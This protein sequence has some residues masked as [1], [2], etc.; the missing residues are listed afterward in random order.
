MQEFFPVANTLCYRSGT[1]GLYAPSM[2]PHI[3]LVQS[4]FI[5][6]TATL[7]A[8][9]YIGW[10]QLGPANL[11]NS[12][13]SI[14]Y[15]HAFGRASLHWAPWSPVYDNTVA[16]PPAQDLVVWQL[17]G[18]GAVFDHT[19]VGLAPPFV[20]AEAGFIVSSS[21]VYSPALL[22]RTA[23]AVGF[24]DAAPGLYSP[25]LAAKSALQ[26]AHL[27]NTPTTYPPSAT[28]GPVY[29]T[30]PSLVVA[31]AQYAPGLYVGAVGV[32]V[33]FVDA[34]AS[35]SAPG[36]TTVGPT[37]V[38]D[39]PVLGG[40]A[41]FSPASIS[42]LTSWLD[43]SKGNL[44]N[45][46]GGPAMEAVGTP[47]P[48]LAAAVSPSG[49]AVAHFA[50][51][52]GRIRSGWAGDVNDF[53]VLYV[54]RATG[55]N[56]GR[57][58]SS[59][60]P[61]SNFLIGFHTSYP[62]AAYN[63][64]LWFGAGTGWNMWSASWPGPWRLYGGDSASGGG[65]RFFVDGLQI[66]TTDT[67]DGDLTRGWAMS[68]YDDSA[69][70]ETMDMDVGEVLVYDRRVSD[71]ERVQLE[72][73]LQAKWLGAG[74]PAGAQSEVYAPAAENIA[75]V[76]GQLGV[77]HLSSGGIY[78]HALLV[79]PVGVAVPLLTS[80]SSVYAPVAAQFSPSKSLAPTLL[81]ANLS[82]FQ[83]VATKF[84]ATKAVTVPVLDAVA[85]VYAPTIVYLAA[86]DVLVAPL[87]LSATYLWDHA[88]YRYS[89]VRTFEAP[90]LFTIP[91]VV[92]PY[93]WP[94]SPMA[95]PLLGSGSL[96]Y[97]PGQAIGKNVM[98]P[99]LFTIPDVF[100]PWMAPDQSAADALANATNKEVFWPSPNI[101][102]T[103]YPLRYRPGPQ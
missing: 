25:A 62:D 6:V 103:V 39:M 26:V 1:P 16:P 24:V 82:L 13:P 101:N 55:P 53:T 81:D 58:F 99:F 8:P 96:M 37:L 95:V 36:I 47:A 42:G 77:P 56:V 92:A 3:N 21:A 23:L 97:A 91:D 98:A 68:G 75:P 93:L 60:Y 74:L 35:I 102:R 27:A 48:S 11:L 29:I 69:P 14:S 20:V 59:R 100:P 61:P 41:A 46:A 50:Y 30:V 78:A 87:L 64:G 57:A 40:G 2:G 38:L 28:V 12:F 5:S 19:V 52:E 66:G 33:G 10:P 17:D 7:Y 4:N 88:A 51:G 73:Y 89:A 43:P 90:L 72:T 32:Q 18:A 79:Q 54:V 83:P 67:T 63:N 80:A 70:G 9:V 15:T 22:P 34:A 49:L 71:V 76:Q 84:S 31:S 65:F 94:T 44:N 85:A 86:A 45:A